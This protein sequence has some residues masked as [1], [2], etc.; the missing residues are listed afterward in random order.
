MAPVSVAG[1]LVF[2]TIGG[3]G[4][5]SR[6]FRKSGHRFCDKNTRK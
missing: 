4:S 2:D 5:R 3:L 6:L 1:G